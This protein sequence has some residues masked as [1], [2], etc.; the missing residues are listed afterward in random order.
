MTDIEIITLQRN[1]AI[2]VVEKREIELMKA[3]QVLKEIDKQLEEYYND[4]QGELNL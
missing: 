1:A 2:N 4:K 3:K